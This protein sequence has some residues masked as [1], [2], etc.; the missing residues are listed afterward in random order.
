MHHEAD[1]PAAIFVVGIE[2]QDLAA[3][4]ACL[5]HGRFQL[6]K[7]TLD[8]A[9]A[10]LADPYRYFDAQQRFRAVFPET[11][12]DDSIWQITM[13]A[14]P[15]AVFQAFHRCCFAHIHV[16]I[17]RRRE[18][19]RVP[20]LPQELP[21]VQVV[22]V[23]LV[24]AEEFDAGSEHAV[25]RDLNIGLHMQ[26]KLPHPRDKATRRRAVEMPIEGFVGVS[27]CLILRV[28]RGLFGF[29]RGDPLG[30]SCLANAPLTFIE[31]RLRDDG[32][33]G[34]ARSLAVLAHLRGYRPHLALG[35]RKY[36]LEK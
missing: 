15:Q 11:G 29:L 19:L 36:S 16:E 17:L 8:E 6:C 7:T 14:Q 3:I 5:A 12:E 25:D 9:F 4:G 10:G 24:D 20:S 28:V 30:M 23:F 31:L 2:G 34:A 32:G 27:K 22:A 18:R 35:L 1:R 33:I 13:T 26:R 21:E